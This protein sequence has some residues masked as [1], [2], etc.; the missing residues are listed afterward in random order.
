M[1][2]ILASKSPRRKE[3]LKNLGIKFDIIQSDIDENRFKNLEPKQ[4]VEKLAFEKAN[5]VLKLHKKENITV[6]GSD[7]IVFIQN[8]I[9]GK[10]KN[11]EDAINMLI[12]LNGKEH[13]VITGLAIIGYKDGKYFEEITYSLAKVYFGKYS[14]EEIKAYVNT[15]EPMDKA[16]AYAIQGIGS[17]LVE[18]IEGDFY[19]IVGLPFQKLYKIFQKYNLFKNTQFNN[20]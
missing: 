11:K 8:E 9:L 3:I 15:K 4:L 19:T 20:K 13:F 6:I 17:F 18:K 5:C 7:T 14:L 2:I 10:P 12:K 16:G 1:Q